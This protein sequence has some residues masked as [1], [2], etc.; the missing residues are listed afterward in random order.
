[1]AAFARVLRAGDRA[2]AQVDEGIDDDRERVLIDA[3]VVQP[4]S[5]KNIRDD[6]TVLA[7]MQNTYAT[8][9][10]RRE[11]NVTDASAIT[12]LELSVSYDDGFVAFLNGTEVARANVPAG[13]NHLTT[14]SSPHEPPARA[15]DR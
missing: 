9:Y 10:V 1:M 15:R 5:V 13:Q 14:A 12:G 8:V 11:F 6:A 7:G 4:A 2:L 3:I